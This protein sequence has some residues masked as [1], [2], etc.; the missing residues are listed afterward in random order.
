MTELFAA[1]A[2]AARDLLAPAVLWRVLWPP[3]AALALCIVIALSVWQPALARLELLLPA[4]PWA[5]FEWVAQWAAVFLLLAGFAA[6]CYFTTLLLVAI[7]VLPGLID[8]V[9]RQ[10][11]PELSRHG[12][13]VFV[14]SLLT[15]LGATVIYLIGGLLSLPLLLIPGAVLVLPLVWT[16]WVNQR[17][18]RF[19][20]L[21]EH[22]T[23]AEFIAL[24]KADRGGFF[25]AGV[26]CATLAHIPVLN[27]LAPGYTALVF[28]HLGLQ[29]LRTL[30]STQGV[31]L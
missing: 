30:R 29:R 16:G 15:T 4:L 7:V 20:A 3:F 12:E 22:A 1:F 25:L 14:G 5:G 18:F 10:A 28:V 11:Y 27:L 19:D 26:G 9:A 23:R 8:R 13:N 21:A 6:L 17:T 2:R 24:I 31:P